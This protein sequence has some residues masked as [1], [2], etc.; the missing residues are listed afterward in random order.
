MSLRAEIEGLRQ[1]LQELSREA[2][3]DLGQRYALRLPPHER[4][5]LYRRL[6]M[7]AGLILRRLGLRATRQLEP[8]L[9][10]LKHVECSD[11]A[12]PLVIWALDI[13]RDTLRAACRGLET[14]HAALPSFVPVLVTDVADFAFFSRLGWLVEYVPTLSAPAGS[15]AERKRRYLAWRYRDAPAL[16]V[17]VGLRKGV[18]KEELLL[19]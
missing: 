7:G 6:R 11:E 14:L 4:L 9:P 8:W 1:R 18:R 13:D 16:P 3:C 10:G 19:V 12:R 5:S 15:Y 17:S 2:E